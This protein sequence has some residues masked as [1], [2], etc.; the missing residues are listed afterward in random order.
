V[1]QRRYIL[2]TE[3]ARSIS[4]KDY[5]RYISGIP[6]L[7]LSDSV[8][9][10][11]VSWSITGNT[12]Q[13]GEPSPESPVKVKGTG[14]KTENLFTDKTIYHLTISE[15]GIL[16]YSATSS[17]VIIKVESNCKYYISTNTI[18]P[19]LRIGCSHTMPQESSAL[20]NYIRLR[21][22]NSAEIKTGSDTE[23]LVF[24]GSQSLENTWLNELY[25]GQG[26]KVPVV[27][28]GK[29]LWNASAFS[30]TSGGFR[31]FFNQESEKLIFEKDKQ[32][33]I[34]FKHTTV[35]T[36]GVYKLCFTY[37]DGTQSKTGWFTTS[38]A[39][40]PFTSQSGKTVLSIKIT[41][42]NNYVNVEVSNIQLELGDTATEYEPTSNLKPQK[43][44][45]AHH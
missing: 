12:V 26:Y 17:C 5:E 41:D 7:I 15:T 39:P 28:R 45:S 38:N 9:K 37:T 21:N 42:Y 13:D 34:S 2:R 19:V 35:S 32:Y 44:I 29:N 24:Q 23:Y 20:S 1:H 25:V 31:D 8:G 30:G 3:Y 33:T 4:S 14:D 40:V 11:L 10:P 6:P 18:L 36:I 27:S 43:S 16:Y 22:T